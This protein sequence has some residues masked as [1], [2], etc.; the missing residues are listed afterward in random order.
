MHGLTR[1][2]QF[3]ISEGHLIIRPDQ[4]EEE[5]KCCLELALYCLKTLG[6]DDEVTYRLSKWDPENKEKYLGDETYWEKTQEI[7]RNILV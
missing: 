3:T 6:I 7:L 1:V 5:L 4:V 2:R